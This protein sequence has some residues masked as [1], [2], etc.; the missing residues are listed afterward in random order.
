VVNAPGQTV[1]LVDLVQFLREQKR[2]AA[3]KLPEYVLQ[4][5]ALPRNPVGKILKR[6]LREQARTLAPEVV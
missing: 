4:I 6:E 1:S 3:Y 2:V 5:D